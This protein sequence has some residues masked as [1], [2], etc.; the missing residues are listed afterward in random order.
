MTVA[1]ES[2]PVASESP[3]V[4]TL[5]VESHIAEESPEV[6]QAVKSLEDAGESTGADESVVAGESAVATL[7][8]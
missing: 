5:H 4:P 6:T 3:I 1:G 2:P 8:C 7:A